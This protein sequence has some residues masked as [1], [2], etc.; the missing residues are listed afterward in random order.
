MF[1]EFIILLYTFL[2]ISFARYKGYMICN[3]FN[4]FSDVLPAFTCTIAIGNLGNLLLLVRICLGVNIL[5][6]QW[7]ETFSEKL[8]SA[9]FIRNILLS[10]ASRN[11]S[12]PSESAYKLLRICF[13]LISLLIL[14]FCFS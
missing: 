8:V 12:L 13:L 6:L 10:K 1:I 5:R 11:L 9:I 2:A 7:S 14:Q 3:K 4:K